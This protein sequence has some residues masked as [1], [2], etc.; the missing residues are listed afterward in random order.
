MV[1]VISVNFI[2]NLTEKL[3]YGII[4]IMIKEVNEP[5]DCPFRYVE[6]WIEYC[7]INSAYC[8]SEHEF[9]KDCLL[10]EKKSILVQCILI[11]KI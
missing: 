10:I 8:F 5:Q 9:P 6:N 7:N 2:E 3:D 1:A 11:K 4:L